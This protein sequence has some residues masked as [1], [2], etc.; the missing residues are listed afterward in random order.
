VGE[1][2]GVPGANWGQGSTF[3]TDL[4]RDGRNELV[5]SSFNANGLFVMERVAG[6]GGKIP[7]TPRVPDP[8]LDY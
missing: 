5:F 8:L 3:I 1:E 2:Y 7:A 6:T 4:N